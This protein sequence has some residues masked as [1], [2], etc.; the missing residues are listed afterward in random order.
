MQY[1]AKMFLTGEFLNLF[2][3]EIVTLSIN[4]TTFI[5][6]HVFLNHLTILIKYNR[7]IIKKRSSL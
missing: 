2:S 3:N 4:P 1:S 5:Q 7:K 6:K